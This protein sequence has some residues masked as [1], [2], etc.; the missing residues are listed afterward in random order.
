MGAFISTIAL[1]LS[2]FFSQAPLEL[3]VHVFGI[4]VQ[5]ARDRMGIDVVKNYNFAFVGQSGSGKSSLINAVRGIGDT[6]P[7]SAT[8]GEIETTASVKSYWFRNNDYVVLWDLPGAGTTQHPSATYFEDK[9]LFAFDC[10]IIVS[11]ER[12]LEVDIQ[13]AVE[14][15]KRNVPVF[16]VRNK[17][18]NSFNSCKKRSPEKNPSV[19]ANE[20]RKDIRTQISKASENLVDRSIYILSSH[21]FNDKSVIQMD[22]SAFA[23]DVMTTAATRRNNGAA[24]HD[25]V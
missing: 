7:D 3:P 14:A 5:S 17:F 25:E 18:D 9:A 1:A 4:S 13:I 15:T 11:S 24:Q 16:F 8:V 12:L 2:A 23:A 19:L 21:A 20:C 10:L 22:E 6:E